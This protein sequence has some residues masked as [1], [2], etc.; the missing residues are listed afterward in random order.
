MNEQ[1]CSWVGALPLMVA[2]HD[3]EWGVPVHDDQKLFEFIVL[4]AMQAGLSWQIVLQK[5]QNFEAAL[6]GFDIAKIAKYSDK[7]LERLVTNEGIIRNRQKLVATVT[8]AKA[9]LAI[10]KEFGSLDSYLWGF[11]DGQAKVNAWKRGSQIPATS[12]AAEAMSK[13][14]KSRGFKFVGPTICYAFMQAAGLVNDHLVECFRY[15]QLHSS[16]N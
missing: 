13:D 9:T 15:E 14:L 8:N 12:I 2:Y 10:Q 4:D 6:D 7:K 5:R 1:R 11:V 16:S 3:T